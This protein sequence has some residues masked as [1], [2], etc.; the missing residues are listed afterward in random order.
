MKKLIRHQ[1]IL[2]FINCL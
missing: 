1:L 2:A